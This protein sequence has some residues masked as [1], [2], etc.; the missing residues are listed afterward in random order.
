MAG[1]GTKVFSK[2]DEYMTPFS[3]WDNIKHFLPKDKVLWEAFYGN[4]QS[5]NNLRQLGFTVVGGE[6]EDFF[7]HN[8]GD[9]VVSNPPFTLVP[10][11]VERL[12]AL[13]KPFVLIMPNP[14]IHTQ[15]IRKLFSTHHLQ[16]IIPRKR[17]QFEKIVDGKKSKE[18]GYCNFDCFYYC[19]RMGLE[20][21]IHFL[22]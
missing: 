21:D 1:F 7:Q 17:I 20:R 16:I 14:K 11:I 3:A 9:V 15:C 18:G 8:K 12:I 2:N 4:G 19:Y 5:F 10:E 13:D 6:D 22:Q